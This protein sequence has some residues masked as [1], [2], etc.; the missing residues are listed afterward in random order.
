MSSPSLRAAAEVVRDRGRLDPGDGVVLIVLTDDFRGDAVTRG[1]E[2]G[3][4]AS[5]VG[6]GGGVGVPVPA[7][8]APSPEGVAAGGVGFAPQRADRFRCWGMF[9]R[10]LGRARRVG[11]G[12][13]LGVPRRGGAMH[14]V[15]YRGWRGG[16]GGGR[17]S[18]RWSRRRDRK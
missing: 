8:P 4:L 12:G 6:V 9:G 2:M 1:G 7:P 17:E 18:E 13:R 14:R 5:G 16:G 11:V 10:A 15:T 3:R